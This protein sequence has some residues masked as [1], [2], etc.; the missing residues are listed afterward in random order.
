MSIIIA[1]LLA[2]ISTGGG[3]TLTYFLARRK[4]KAETL[5][6]ELDNANKV[7]KIWQELNAEL[8][9]QIKD[10]ELKV[11]DMR[12]DM[13]VLELKYRDQCDKCDYKKKHLT[14]SK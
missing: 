9:N 14:V 3:S 2:L 4:T 11:D 6:I 7:I 13:K 10:L 8:K 1:I 12:N 5:S